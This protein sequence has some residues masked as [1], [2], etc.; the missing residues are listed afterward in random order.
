MRWPQ[1]EDGFNRTKT[2]V[3]VERTIAVIL[4]QSSDW[5]TDCCPVA[6]RDGHDLPGLVDECV[7]SVSCRN[8]HCPKCQG[9]A[10]AQWLADR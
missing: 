4:Y 5:V 8:R 2:A 10:Q 7:P 1:G 6:L 3:R 9:L